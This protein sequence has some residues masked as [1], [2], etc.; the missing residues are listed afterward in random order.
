MSPMLITPHLW[1]TCNSV[2]C[3]IVFITLEAP[4]GSS[5]EKLAAASGRRHWP[6]CW[7]CL[8]PGPGSFD[9]DDATTLS[10]SSA[11]VSEWVSWESTLLTQFCFFYVF[12]YPYI[13]IFTFSWF[14]SNI[15]ICT[16]C[17]LLLWRM[18]C[19]TDEFWL[20]ERTLLAKLSSSATTSSTLR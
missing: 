15:S 1:F 4:A 8:D 3:S 19:R 7:C 17:L 18:N 12:M 13:Y 10:W 14:I 2:A 16:Y 20:T 11:A 6:S 5:M 9:V